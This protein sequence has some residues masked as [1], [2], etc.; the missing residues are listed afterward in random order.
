VYFSDDR[1]P[2]FKASL[3]QTIHPST[4]NASKAMKIAANSSMACHLYGMQDS[5]RGRGQLFASISI[6]F[7][8][9]R[10]ERDECVFVRSVN[11]SKQNKH[12]MPP[13]LANIS[14]ATSFVPECDRI[15]PDCPHATAILIIA[16]YVDD[17]LA[18]TNC[19]F[20]AAAFETHCNLKFPINGD[21]V[22]M[23][24]PC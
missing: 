21:P 24:I 2:S 8:L 9:T 15:Y 18:F 13:N 23:L 3:I 17:N 6:D 10:L 7:G 11:N 1:S 22:Y 4:V 20:L 19:V 5:P 14:E 16:S 12:Y